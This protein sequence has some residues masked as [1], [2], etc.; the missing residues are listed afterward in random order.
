MRGHETLRF[1][2]RRHLSYAN[3]MAS[4]AV[5]AVFGGVSYAAANINGNQIVK[6]TVGGAKLKNGTITSTSTTAAS[7]TA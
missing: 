4:V 5:F 1:R 2:L 6:G 3:V 7:S